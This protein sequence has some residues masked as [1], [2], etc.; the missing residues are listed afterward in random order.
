MAVETITITKTLNVFL[1]KLGA[2][3]KLEKPT[4]VHTRYYLCMMTHTTTH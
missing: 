3:V 4:F 1:V 2:S